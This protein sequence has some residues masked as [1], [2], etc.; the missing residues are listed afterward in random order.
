[1]KLA[2]A[3][4]SDVFESSNRLK[5]DRISQFFKIKVLIIILSNALRNPTTTKNPENV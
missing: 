4:L 2:F 5:K 3:N 1:M